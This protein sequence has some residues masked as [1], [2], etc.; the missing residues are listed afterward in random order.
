[1]SKLRVIIF[2]IIIS[3]FLSFKLIF[4]NKIYP[5]VKVASV[6]LMGLTKAEAREKIEKKIF[7]DRAKLLSF[8][9]SEQNYHIDLS[10]GFIIESDQA[11][12]EAY[13]FGRTKFSYPPPNVKIHTNFNKQFE[14]SIQNIAFAINIEAIDSQLKV[15]DSQINVTPSQDGLVLDEDELK[16]KIT[17]YLNT[18]LIDNTIP[19]KKK[20]PNLNYEQALSLKQSLDEIKLSPIQLKFKDRLWLLDL[21]TALNLI[22]I[23]SSNPSLASLV[24][25]DQNI[26]IPKIKVGKEVIEDRKIVLNQKALDDYLNELSLDINQAVEEPLFNFDGVKVVEFRPPLEGRKLNK[27]ISASLITNAILAKQK[28][29]ELPVDITLPKNKLTND[30]GIKELVGRGFS[31]FAGSIPN[32]VFNISLAAS[33]INGVLIAPN[34][35]FSFN[36]T[37]GDISSA[38]GYKQA[39]VIKSG[40]TVLDDGGGVCQVSTTLFRTVLN[41]GLP[42]IAR[43]AH[44]YRVGYYEQ[45]FPPGLD[46]TIFSPN[47]DFKFKNDT[48]HHILI[49]A[50]IIGNSLYIDFYGTKDGRV[51]K[52]ST[53]VVTNQ[54]PPPPELRQDDP[55]LPKGVVKQVDF[56]AWGANVVF[57][58][59]VIRNGETIIN[60]SFRSN[61]RPWQA[62]YLV[63]TQ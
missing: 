5:G 2:I 7:K 35:E 63:G 25:N 59:T 14:S 17:N 22:D 31:N 42:V 15:D 20:L 21:E 3:L 54:T 1:M 19:T 57:S 60:E 46:A 10:K 55:T 53:P 51:A 39:Y 27:D 4:L 18:G 8:K 24:I 49:Q 52:I 23:E 62:V 32:R 33:R 40:R 13:Q 41:S 44:A 45:G 9:Q 11:I 43:T 30:L 36:K 58:R 48:S 56:A 47:V 28:Q 50:Y 37:V 16:V 34:E 26:N 6:D 29:I 12:D 38:S 61:F